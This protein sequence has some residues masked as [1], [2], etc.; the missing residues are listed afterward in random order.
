MIKLA[1]VFHLWV[2]LKVLVR[3]ET[4]RNLLASEQ[5]ALSTTEATEFH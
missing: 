1:G 2:Q 4:T 5:R 3:S